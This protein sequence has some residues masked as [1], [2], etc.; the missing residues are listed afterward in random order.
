MKFFNVVLLSFICTGTLHLLF[1]LVDYSPGRRIT[2]VL[3]MPFLMLWVYSVFPD[4]LLLSALFWGW[5]GDCLLIKKENGT[6]LRLGILA[7]LAGHLTYVL[8]FVIHIPAFPGTAAFCGIFFPYLLFGAG[9]FRL[10][11]PGLGRM[12]FP[13]GVYIFVI[14]SMSMSAL[15]F[16][17]SV[18]GT[19][20][21]AFAGSLLF[22]FS[23]S[24]LSFQ[25]FMKP[26]KYGRFVVMASY[27][28]A[29]F[30]LVR[31]FLFR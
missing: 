9:M 21:L 22:V 23:D 27:I 16:A 14:S 28:P 17:L 24:V 15:L 31:G 10:L 8:L 4:Y 6:F 19:A 1:V 5:L 12:V 26:F 29:Q 11:R 2:K 7:F 25:L 20:W 30:L 13:V 3:L 18:G